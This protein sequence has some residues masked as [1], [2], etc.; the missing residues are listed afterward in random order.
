MECL[1]DV[2]RSS[3]LV[4][5]LASNAVR[6]SFGRWS[7]LEDADTVATGIAKLYHTFLAELE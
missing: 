1:R 2:G 4:E 6:V 7:S 5:E 3:E